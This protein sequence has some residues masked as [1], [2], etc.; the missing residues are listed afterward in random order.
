MDIGKKDRRKDAPNA[1]RD[2]S[3]PTLWV[4]GLE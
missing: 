3:I 2:R 1:L 4:V